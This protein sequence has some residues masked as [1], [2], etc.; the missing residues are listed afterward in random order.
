M[1]RVEE[2]E[3][4]VNS[5]R[6]EDSEHKREVSRLLVIRSDSLVVIDQE[7]SS[8]EDMTGVRKERYS[9]ARDGIEAR[10]LARGRRL[11]HAGPLVGAM[12]IE[13]GH[14]HE[15]TA[16]LRALNPSAFCRK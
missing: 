16:G 9:H 3:L 11:R 8:E 15:E 7:A 4:E 6:V 1:C 12:S 10:G 2:D 5:L 13:H 14:W